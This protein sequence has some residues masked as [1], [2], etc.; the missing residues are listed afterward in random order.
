MCMLDTNLIST[1]PVVIAALHTYPQITAADRQD[2]KTKSRQSKKRGVPAGPHAPCHEEA[3]VEE[4]RLEG[5]R[6][7][8][9][10]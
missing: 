5:G 6:S 3:R 2:D 7:R 9:D 8:D 1:V 10:L 4:E